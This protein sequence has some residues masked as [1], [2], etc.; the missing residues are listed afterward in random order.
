MR[1]SNEPTQLELFQQAQIE[2]LQKSLAVHKELLLEIQ[3]AMEK[4]INNIEVEL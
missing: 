1:T 4:Y 2:A 3:T